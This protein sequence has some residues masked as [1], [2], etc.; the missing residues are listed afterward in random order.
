[1]AISERKYQKLFEEAQADAIRFRKERDDALG[2]IRAI[3]RTLEELNPRNYDQA[4]VERVNNGSIQGIMMARAAIAGCPEPHEDTARLDAV[5]RECADVEL[6]CGG[7]W[8][9]SACDDYEA[10]SLRGAIDKLIAATQP[11]AQS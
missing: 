11:E 6:T 10:D 1:M 7:A 9:V 4:D 5:E 8:R 3:G 2:R